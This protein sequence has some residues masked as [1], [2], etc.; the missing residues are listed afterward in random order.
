MESGQS[1]LGHEY[2][3]KIYAER[4]TGF[5]LPFGFQLDSQLIEPSQER[6]I[7][8]ALPPKLVFKVP[9]IVD[10]GQG[11]LEDFVFST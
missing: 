7:C 1:S 2:N 9:C 10:L 8:L 3:G 6:L 4:P 5:F 11:C